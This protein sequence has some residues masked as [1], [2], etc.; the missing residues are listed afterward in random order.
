VGRKLRAAWSKTD[1]AQ[2]ERDLRAL[3]RALESKHPGAAGSILEGL[4]E[5]LT[6]TRLGL[7]PSLLRTFKSPNPVESMISIARDTHCNVKRW[8]DGKMALRW[9]AAGMLEA[10]KQFRR[11]NGHRDLHILGRALDCHKE[12]IEGGKQVA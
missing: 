3:A 1:A 4:E 7:T 5:T 8:R 11:V 10:E 6:V 12:V 9:I 2:A